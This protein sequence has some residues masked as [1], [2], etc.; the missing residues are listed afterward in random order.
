MTKGELFTFLKDKGLLEYGSVIRGDII[1][2]ELEIKLPERGTKQEFSNAALAEL[3]AVDYIR[4]ILLGQGKYLASTADSYRILL[5]SENEV[6]CEKYT[7]AAIKK[8]K[9]SLKLSQNTPAGDH[10]RPDRQT[11]RAQLQLSSI[12]RKPGEK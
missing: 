12:R 9:R 6:Q 4:N 8:L 11:M 5:A 2:K 10:P 3:K 7:E 1:R